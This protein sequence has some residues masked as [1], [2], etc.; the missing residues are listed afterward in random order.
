MPPVPDD[1]EV[2]FASYLP[3]RFAGAQRLLGNT[4]SVGSLLFRVD[5][6][7]EW[8]LRLRDGSLETVRTMEDDVVLQ[9][10]VSRE[11][12]SVLVVEALERL[13]AS[14]RPLTKA[15]AFRGL[16]Q[17]PETARLVRH[18]PGSVLLVLRDGDVKRRLLVTPGRRKADFTGAEC[19]VECGLADWVEA[20]TGV[21]S[22]ID[23]FIGGKLK[24]AGNVQIGMAL[25][26]A[27]A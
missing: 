13:E 12:F 5:G 21:K 11:D 27:L 24:V 20:E 7:G 19:T 26:G 6:V 1:P 2:L 22:P 25:A 23:L 16:K 10:T 15:S 18:V 17:D 4:S 3:E 8:S 14:D 9:V